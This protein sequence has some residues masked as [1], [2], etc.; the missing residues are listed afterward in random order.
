MPPLS[1]LG[2]CTVPPDGVCKTRKLPCFN[3]PAHPQMS[4]LLSLLV[5]HRLLGGAGLHAW[6]WMN[7]EKNLRRRW[8][9]II[10]AMGKKSEFRVESFGYRSKTVDFHWLQKLLCPLYSWRGEEIKLLALLSCF[11]L[12][13][14]QN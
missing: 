9:S 11:F 10:D 1:M 3:F 5:V 12:L 8:E 4:V 2:A 6:P 13:F 14:R 7:G